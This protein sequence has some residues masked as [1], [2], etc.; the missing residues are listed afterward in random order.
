MKKPVLKWK[1]RNRV[2]IALACVHRYIWPY[3]IIFVSLAVGG[4]N[5]LLL[6]GVGMVLYAAYSVIGYQLRWKHIY[7]SYQNAYREEMTPQHIRW[8]RIK[9]SDAYGIPAIIAVIGIGAIV[10]HC[11]FC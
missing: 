10:C 9:K 4:S 6:M 5:L 7:C 2:I 3:F 11:L 1:T 8:G